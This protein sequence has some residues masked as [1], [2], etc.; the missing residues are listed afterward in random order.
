MSKLNPIWLILFAILASACSS[1]DGGQGTSTAA[2]AS[3]RAPAAAEAPAP[4]MK[5]ELVPAPERKPAAVKL[6]VTNLEE[7]QELTEQE[8]VLFRFAASSEIK[9]VKI[10]ANGKL[11]GNAEL[12][13]AELRFE[14]NFAAS[15]D[16]DLEFTGYGADLSK[17]LASV[18]RRVSIVPHPAPAPAPSPIRARYF[19]SYVIKAT[20]LL[21]E[22]YA[23]LGYNLN[24]Q[25]THEMK[26]HTLGTF[27]PNGDGQT[28]CVA[29]ML[30]VMVTALDL[31]TKE[32][33]DTS[34][35]NFLPFNS[36]SSL[37]PGT[38]KASMW[39]NPKLRSNGSGD[40]LANF[41]MGE[42]VKFSEL[43]PGGFINLNRNRPSG[44]A[45]VFLAFIDKNARELPRY[46]AEVA[47]FKYFSAQG[48][49]IKG[50]G[51]FGY[52]YAF[53]SK[54]GCPNVPVKRDCDVIF[55]EKQNLLN[56]GMMLM[57]YHWKRVQPLDGLG[58][59]AEDAASLLDVSSSLEFD[60]LTTDD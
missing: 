1:K 51:G 49:R 60:G 7:N 43:E 12:R 57:P 28:M 32:T 34:P 11:L 21:N 46:S 17:P 16:F 13:A 3:P 33:G 20:E 41:G 56:T 5:P 2:A 25:F 58:R 19:N 48:R 23:G 31:Y 54:N 26:F 53:F 52:R 44:H 39:V 14:T 50:Q 15:G 18:K 59:I 8:P 55:S 45:V 47:G 10:S 6:E 38:F 40:A 22:R 24:K 9:T 27:R 30:E 4:V 29:A 36:W 37:K 42:R 35:Y